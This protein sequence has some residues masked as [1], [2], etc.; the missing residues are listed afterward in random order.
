MLTSNITTSSGFAL[1]RTVSLNGVLVEQRKLMHIYLDEDRAIQASASYCENI[2]GLDAL[3]G[4]D[5]GFYVMP[6]AF[7]A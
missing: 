5:F 4:L 3:D 7:E 6:V 2:A 1:Y